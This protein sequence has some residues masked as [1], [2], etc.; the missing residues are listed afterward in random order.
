ML[1][2]VHHMHMKDLVISIQKFWNV[3]IDVPHTSGHDV[4]QEDGI[5]NDVKLYGST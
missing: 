1:S 5:S 3:F 4:F 2:L